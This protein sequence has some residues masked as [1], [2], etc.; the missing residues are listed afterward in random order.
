MRTSGSGNTATGRGIPLSL[1]ILIVLS[2]ATITVA[3]LK[4]A[5]GIVAPVFLATV[6]VI[7]VYP[8]HRRLDRL[9]LPGWLAAAVTILSVYLML[10]LMARALIV[11]VSR[12]TVLIPQYVLQ[13]KDLVAQAAALLDSWGVGAQQI[14]A[15]IRSIDVS[16]LVALAAT[17]FSGTLD[18]VSTLT[19]V[20]ILVL[21]TGSD[22]GVFARSVLA[23]RRQRAAVVD[24]LPGFAHGTRRY[25]AVAS[26]L[27]PRGSDSSWRC[28]TMQPLWCWAFRVHSFGPYCPLSPT[29]FPTSVF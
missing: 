10:V 16:Q 8:V 20:A 25:F 2:A 7:T 11:S 14:H 27:W 21:F 29:S 24:A 3:G 4:A 19:L 26:G 1:L 13:L 15:V 22:S 5:A 23:A 17:V 9:G 6:L 18:V 28:S 12:L